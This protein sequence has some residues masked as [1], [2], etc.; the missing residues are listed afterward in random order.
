M[1]RSIFVATVLL[2]LLALGAV[3]ASSTVYYPQQAATYVGSDTCLGCHPAIGGGPSREDFEATLHPWKLRPKDEAN[4]IGQFPVTDVNGVTWT[5]D[6]VDWVIG[7]NGTG[8]KQRYIKIID[9]VW[10]ILPIQWNLATQEWVPYHADDW[11][12]G[13]PERD[14]KELCA[15]CHTTGYDVT[16]KEWSEPGVWCEACHGPGSQHFGN[17][18]GI[19]KTPDSET[20]GQC[21]VR[22]HDKDTDTHGWPVG[23]VP[24]GDTHIEDV[25]NYDWSSKRWWFDNPDDTEDPGHAKSHHQQYMEWDMSVHSTA[26]PDLLASGHASESCLGCHSQDYRDDPENVT[27]E[28][29]QYSIEC[30]TCHTPHSVG[31]GAHQLELSPYDTC[32]Q[33]HN[34]HLPE[35]GKFE[36][37]STI[38][39]PMQE[40]FEG[41][42][43]PGIDDIPSPHFAAEGGPVC[44]SCHFA[45]TAKSA[46]PGDISSHLLKPVMPG[47][48][49]EGEQDSC[50]G[51]H[52]GATRERM[53][54]IIDNRQAEI[55]RELGE[56][57]T[58]LDASQAI[59]D[60]VAYKTAYTAH[61]MV[62]SEGSF[63]IH[64][65]WYAKSVLD[66]G[67]AQLGAAMTATSY[68]G[69]DSCVGCH[70]YKDN[71]PEVT[72]H[73]DETLHPWKLRPKDEANILADW[74]VGE[75]V[76]TTVIGGEERAFTLDD[77]DYVIGASG[78]GW[79]QRFVKE[80]DGVW[81]ILPAQWNLATEEWVPYHPDTHSSPWTGR[82]Y[83]VL[84]SGCH[85]T[86]VNIDDPEMNGGLGFVDFGVTCEGC[87]GAGR[88]HV[89]GMGDKT[90]ITKS[91][92]SEVCASCHVRG[93]TKE[94]LHDVRYGWP[95]GYVPGSE[96]GSGTA[97][98]DVYDLDWSTGKW[99]YDNPEDAEDP[100]HA[101]GHHQQ[102][103]EW[104]MSAHA[105][106]LD[107]L[108]ASGHASEHCLGCHSEDYRR[109]PENVTV[110][111]AEFTIECVTC[112][113]THDPGAEGTSQLHMSQ[114]ETCV[115]CHTGGLEEGGKFT[116]GSTVHHPMQ[117]MFEGVGALGVDTDIPSRHFA[118]ES[119]PVCSSC[120]LAKTAKSAVWTMDGDR[121]VKGDI[122]SHLLKP[123]L[124]GDVQAGEPDSCGQCHSGNMQGIIDTRQADIKSRIADVEARLANLDAAKGLPVRDAA[125]TDLTLVESEGSSGIHN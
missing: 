2:L 44:S 98:E 102:Y 120:H 80:I 25:Y 123:A 32:V 99:W 16:T 31:S 15:G 117:E 48:A 45:P 51:C 13:T 101:S 81:R 8:W 61:S 40:M 111:T 14:Y 71:T 92:S 97:L 30:V 94:G 76:R 49:Q 103:M 20:C 86:G 109:D 17:P 11:A 87:H 122:S 55:K 90:K 124:P 38:H 52:T 28:T 34:G 39:H 91:V 108:V 24:G 50:T 78:R 23:Y 119:G 10:R 12:D 112:H 82:D 73:F 106:A 77:V 105:N 43:F 84:C 3:S 9:G 114:Y 36:A 125:Y 58:V 118:N 63:G 53:Q 74:T 4:I 79:K 54:K 56:L 35:S 62:E 113:V 72:L 47:E 57:Q 104:D 26:L 18:A 6:D 64:N 46:L 83:K 93:K 29:A 75:D 37:G 65:Y 5:L 1:K 67:F 121:V 22:G 27:V 59:S 69:A 85:N 107:D 96:P 68:A 66:E 41:I 110:D 89:L 21:H 100:G 7:A 115:Q 95:E 88:D 33:C 70:S 19:V 60:T 42:G 116:A